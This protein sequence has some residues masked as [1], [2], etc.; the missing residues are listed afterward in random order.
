MDT[1]FYKLTVNGITQETNDT[2]SIS[3]EVPAELKATFAYKQGQYLTLRFDIKGNEVRRAYSMSS[4]PQEEDLT[5]SVK[6]VKGGVVSNH[7]ADQLTIGSEIEVMPPQGRFYTHLE[8]TQRKTYYLFAAG[9]GITPLMSILKTVLEAEPQS[10]VHLIYGNRSEQDIIFKDQLA[11]LANRYQHQ[12]Y[13][14]HVLSQPRREKSGLFGMFQKGTLSWQGEIGRISKAFVLKYMEENPSNT[15]ESS[16]FVCGPGGMIDEVEAT[17]LSQSI[18]KKHIL[19]ERFTSAAPKAAPLSAGAAML[20]V[21]LKKEVFELE[22]PAKKTILEALIADKKNPPYSCTSGACSSC[23]AKV[24]SGTVTMD[25]CY[26]LDDDE[27][28]AGYIL[29]CQARPTSSSVEIIFE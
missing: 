19:T 6:R 16:Y 15:K 24:I 28:A 27:V 8:E 29:T 13:V 18:E 9:S 14:T 3:L 22:I 11:G 21:T 17:L 7:I 5:V 12:L 4:S 2:V 1:N 10:I 25:A 23:M 20:V 26:A